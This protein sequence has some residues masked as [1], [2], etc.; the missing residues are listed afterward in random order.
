L[1]SQQQ[2]D[3]FPALP[4]LPTAPGNPELTAAPWEPGAARAGALPPETW[5]REAALPV[6]VAGELLAFGQVR[7][8]DEG[9]AVQPGGSVTDAGLAWRLPIATGTE[10]LL[11][12]GPEFGVADPSHAGRVPTVAPV[13]LRAQWLRL[14]VQCRWT[15]PGSVG[16]ECQGTTCPALEAGDH[17]VFSQELRAVVPVGSGQFRVG[18]RHSWEDTGGA[19]T[20]SDS[21]ELFGGFRLGW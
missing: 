1:P 4:E 21:M 5:R 10:F 15:L 19:K 20:G 14:D 18:A 7:G 11:G 17:N 6:P 8:A 2:A 12:G 3:E 9:G 13:P 16:L